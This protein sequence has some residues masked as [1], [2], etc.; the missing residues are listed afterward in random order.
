[1]LNYFLFQIFFDYLKAIYGKN[2]Y[3]LFGIFLYYFFQ[4]MLSDQ[5]LKSSNISK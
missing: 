2:K 1:M 5:A 4:K 3:I